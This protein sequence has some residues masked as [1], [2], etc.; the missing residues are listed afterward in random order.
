MIDNIHI[1]ELKETLKS[2][3]WRQINLTLQ[4]TQ[5][6][7]IITHLPNAF[8]FDS[9]ADSRKGRF[10]ILSA[11]PVDIIALDKQNI[12]QP[13]IHS[14]VIKH[15]TQ[16]RHPSPY[17]RLPFT[18][19]WIGYCSYDYGANCIIESQKMLLDS[20]LPSLY[21]GRY[22]WSYVYDRNQ[23]QGFITF[24]PECETA[25]KQ[26]IIDVITKTCK[27]TPHNATPN[28]S[29]KVAFEK[30]ITFDEYKAKFK[31]IKTYIRKGDCYQVN[32]AQRFES[33]ITQTPIQ[34]Y[35]QLRTNMDTPYSGFFSLNKNSNILCFSP[36]QFISIDSRIIETRPIKGTA[37]NNDDNGNAENLCKSEKNKAENLMIVDL[38]RNDLS[39]ICQYGSITVKELYQLESFNNVHHLV[40][41]IIGKL[42]DDITEL[43]AF[44][45]CFPGG[46]ITGAPKKRAMEI[47]EQLEESGRDAYC[48]SVF[49]LDDTGKFDS[50]IL[51]RSI[52]HSGNRLF[53]WGGGAITDDSDVKE[54]YDES[55]VK[56]KNLTNITS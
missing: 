55:L 23:K 13:D 9:S 31:T 26:Q 4:D 7:Q 25:L 53:C 1:K 19:G 41:H 27:E 45:S 44:F 36:E 32:F 16:K 56:V 17:N 5:I 50:N 18:C 29:Q 28:F 35:F 30:S 40:S 2:N 8:F 3:A 20:N 12:E 24:S 52:V 37:E 49:Y 47:I 54:E 33:K 34:L 51:I 6:A 10:D 48:G 21:L 22:T 38:L 14:R 43:E 39:K 15:S 46:S 42:R 11:A